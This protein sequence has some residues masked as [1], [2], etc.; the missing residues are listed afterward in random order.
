[1]AKQMDTMNS[2]EAAEFFDIAMPTL[3]R[4]CCEKRIPYSK[5]GKKR[6]FI[7]EDLERIVREA[8][9]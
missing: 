4:W 8:A 5:I 6:T 9:A 1:M 3:N 7:R 2:K